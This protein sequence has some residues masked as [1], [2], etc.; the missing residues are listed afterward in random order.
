MRRS[1]ILNT[2]SARMYDILAERLGQA[3]RL[4]LNYKRSGVIGDLK[5]A[6]RVMEQVINMAPTGYITKRYLK[7]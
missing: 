2:M 5:E 6:I 4:T 7:K 1:E 3:M